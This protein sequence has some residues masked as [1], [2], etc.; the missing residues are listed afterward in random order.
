MYKP[1]EVMTHCP[2]IVVTGCGEHREDN[3]GPGTWHPGE[4]RCELSFLG[5]P[6]ECWGQTA[7]CDSPVAIVVRARGPGRIDVEVQCQEGHGINVMR[8]DVTLDLDGVP[9][10]A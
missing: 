4:Y 7:R 2:V 1:D 10:D 5:Q 3:G 9:I 8:R 6:G